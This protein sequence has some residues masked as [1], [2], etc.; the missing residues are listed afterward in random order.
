M[1]KIGFWLILVLIGVI[2]ASQAWSA[3]PQK[4]NIQG[5]LTP[6]PAS[7]PISMTFTIGTWTETNNIPVETTTGIFSATIGGTIPIDP[8]VFTGGT[9]TLTITPQTPYPAITQNLNSVPYAFRALVAENLAAGETGAYVKKAGD[10]MSGVLTLE[11]GARAGYGAVTPTYG[12]RVKSV[13]TAGSFESVN[14]YGVY[15][16]AATNEAA[17]YGENTT[18]MDGSNKAG[19]GV[20]GKGNSIGV[21]GTVANNTIGGVGVSGT[22]TY[23]YGIYGKGPTSAWFDGN[24]SVRGSVSVE[25]GMLSVYGTIESTL[26]GYK[27]PDGTIQTTAVVGAGGAGW[28]TDGSTK[29]TTMYKVGIGTPE[30][31]FKLSLDNDGGILAKGTFGSGKDLLTKGQGTRLIW[32]PKKAAFRAGYVASINYNDD[33]IG[34]YS[35]ATGN[36]TLAAGPSSTATGRFTQA[37][38]SSSTAMGETS[39]AYGPASFAAGLGA[40]A[41]GNASS[42]MGFQTTAGSEFATAIGMSTFANG[43]ASTAMGE[44][45][46]ASGEASTAMGYRTIA[47][48]MGATAMGNGSIA[49]GG[50]SVAMGSSVASGL[51]STAMGYGSTASGNTSVAMGYLTSAAGTYSFAAGNRA[52]ANDD[53][54]F[55]FGDSSASDVT[56][57]AANQWTTRFAGGIRFYTSSNL[58]S[59]ATLAAGGSSWASVSDVN[60]KEN[61]NAVNPIEVVNKLSQ[62][63]ITTW[64]YKTQSPSIRHM[65]PTAQDLYAA[66]SLGEDD[67]HID[68]IDADGVALAAIQGLHLIAKDQQKELDDQ[69]KVLQSQETEINN[70]KSQSQQLD[71]RVRVLEEKIK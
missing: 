56:S 12:I 63:P 15:A 11:A 68:T 38:G 64:N 46:I 45:S 52:K 44:Y 66:F 61:F 9:A 14:G 26:G 48:G 30:P 41:K 18:A 36:D 40:I 32:Y 67:K 29:T 1:K 54:S 3:I 24:V 22:S 6:V 62:I 13:S 37:F 59:G 25:A 10:T 19:I 42:A 50:A 51:Y 35:F 57:S 27:F 23:G 58:V 33:Y 34:F 31:E 16:K 20:E 69:Q 5:K 28:T 2:A 55:V 8:G 70:L 21:R 53:G 7:S 43:S 49:S 65:G 47:S 17:V 39:A 71:D 60:L 4:I